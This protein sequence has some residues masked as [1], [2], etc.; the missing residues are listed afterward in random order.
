MTP[1]ELLAVVCPF[2]PLAVRDRGVQDLC[3]WTVTSGFLS[4]NGRARISEPD[5]GRIGSPWPQAPL[6]DRHG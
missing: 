6:M 5:G 3:I 2:A 4:M 1:H